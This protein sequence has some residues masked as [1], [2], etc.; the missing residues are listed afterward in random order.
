MND[1]SRSIFTLVLHPAHGYS[2]RRRVRSLGAVL[3][4]ESHRRMPVH[5]ARRGVASKRR[6]TGAHVDPTRDTNQEGGQQ[7]LL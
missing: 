6:G 4:L 7:C 2:P 1:S 3:D 5:C